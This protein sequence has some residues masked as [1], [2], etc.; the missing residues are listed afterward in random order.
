MWQADASTS[1]D[2]VE[3]ALDAMTPL[4]SQFFSITLGLP[5]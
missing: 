4:T 5:V 3:S 1:L 2:T